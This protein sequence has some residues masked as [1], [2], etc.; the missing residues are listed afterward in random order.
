[1]PTKSTRFL[2]PWILLLALL[3]C[4]IVA[5]QP[6]PKPSPAGPAK[7]AY[8]KA[9]QLVKAGKLNEAQQLLLATSKPREELYD[10]QADPHELT[11][12]AQSP[13]HRKVLLELRTLLD[14]WIAETGDK[15]L[16][17]LSFMSSKE[18]GHVGD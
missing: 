9:T 12:L 4:M 11:N 7:A 17:P 1:M 13:S 6:T 15:G 16:A 14:G 10:L 2:I 8:D 5:Q 18:S 3:P